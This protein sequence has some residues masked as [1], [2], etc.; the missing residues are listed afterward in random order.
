M[1]KAPPAPSVRAADPV[2]VGADVLG[3]VP[4]LL[5]EM[6]C[7]FTLVWVSIATCLHP[8]RKS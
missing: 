4:A 3:R 7:M 1:S 8:S 6:V 5:A 2:V